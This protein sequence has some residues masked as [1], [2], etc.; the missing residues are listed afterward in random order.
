MY[1]I[2]L[3]RAFRQLKVDPYDFPLLCLRWRDEFFCDTSVPFGHRSGGLGCIRLTSA[4]G[5]IHSLRGHHVMTYFD[6]MI[7]GELPEN[8]ERS[9]N[10]LHG[11]L[12]KLHMPI[13]VSK[14]APPSTRI[15][16][17]GIEIDSTS[18]TLAISEQKLNEIV[19]KCSEVLKKKSISV[20][21][22]QFVIGLLLFIHKAVKPA[23]IFVN[24]ML[25]SL[26]NSQGMEFVNV[27]AEMLKDLRWFVKFVAKYNGCSKY[28]HTP[29][30]S[31]Q[32]VE[33]DASLGA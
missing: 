12:R 18:Q 31:F 5:Y 6:D 21:H 17:L 16:C 11:L 22:L 10:H 13:S 7:S 14:L 25:Q 26:R 9:F 33:L 27:D 28:V 15:T 32:Q 23:R 24:R 19:H 30:Q 8:A 1:K 20:K 29:I 3:A 4:I 2:D